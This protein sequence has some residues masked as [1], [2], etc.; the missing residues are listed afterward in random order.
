M[1]QPSLII[2]ESP[3]TGPEDPRVAPCV[4]TI[5]HVLWHA[6]LPNRIPQGQ[7]TRHREKHNS[8]G[9]SS[10]GIC[11]GQPCQTGSSGFSEF[12][13]EL[14]L[15]VKGTSNHIER[16]V[17]TRIHSPI[18]ARTHALC[19]GR[20][21][22]RAAAWSLRYIQLALRVEVQEGNEKETLPHEL[23]L[24]SGPRGRTHLRLEA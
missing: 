16:P 8:N 21:G 12:I 11:Q 15:L 24:D 17:H 2:M 5:P 14:S 7:R 20:F 19:W 9:L 13:F 10:F 18:R 23:A 22:R 1:R 6:R 3:D 4:P